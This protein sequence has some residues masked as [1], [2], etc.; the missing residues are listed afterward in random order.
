VE[1]S[2]WQTAFSVRVDLGEGLTARERAILMNA[3]RH[4]EVHKLL[5]G[6]FVFDYE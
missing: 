5:S 2:S 1:G 3:A 6:Q 4:C